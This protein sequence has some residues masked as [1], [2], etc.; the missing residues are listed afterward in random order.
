MIEYDF[1]RKHSGADSLTGHRNPT[2]FE[3]GFG[4]G[5][6]HYKDFPRKLWLKSDGSIKLWT[7]CPQD[8][9]RYYRSKY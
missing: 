4:S 8:G 5:A 6:I 3:I 9:L 2:A 1:F 7:V